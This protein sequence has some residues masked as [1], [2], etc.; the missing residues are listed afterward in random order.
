MSIYTCPHCGEKSFN[1]WTKAWAGQFN[2]RGKPC[3]KCGKLC[4][5]GKG[6]TIFNAVY[7]LLAFICVIVIYLNGTKNA[8]MYYHEVPMVAGLLLSMF[9][10]PKIVNAFFFKLEPSIRIEY[11]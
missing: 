1:P 3:I 9:I 8:W 5:N 10:V 7:S 11:K 6:A 4:V 2:S